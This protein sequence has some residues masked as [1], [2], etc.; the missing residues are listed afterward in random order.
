[1]AGVFP[2]PQGELSLPL[3]AQVIALLDT[4]RPSALT[5][6]ERLSQPLHDPN[7]HPLDLL[8]MEGDI[9]VSYLAIPS[10]IISLA[11]YT[12]KASGLSGV[13]THPLNR[14][15]GYGRQLVTAARD[16]IAASDADI[17][18]FTSDP[19]LVS[20]YVGCGWTLMGDTSIVGGTRERPFPADELGK[21]T[22][23]GFFSA[24]A[25]QHR[26]DFVGASLHLGL[27]EGDLW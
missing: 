14:H 16:L 20:F 7:R 3:K 23:M 27:R 25:K 13:I 1:M 15:R 6:A 10:T 9:V 4:E 19:P 24:Q 11:G 12:Y 17:G 22:L 21:R 5:I 2:Y 26:R 8:L 18:V